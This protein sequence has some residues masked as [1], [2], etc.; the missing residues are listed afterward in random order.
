MIWSITGPCY[1]GILELVLV[2]V[3]GGAKSCACHG[4]MVRDVW[5]VDD[6]VVM[7][8]MNVGDTPGKRGR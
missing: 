4:A 1:V 6:G 7:P 5:L 3:H 8:Q 2:L